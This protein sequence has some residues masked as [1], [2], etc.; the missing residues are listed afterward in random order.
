MRQFLNHRGAHPGG[1][2]DQPRESVL[3][4][5]ILKPHEQPAAQTAR[6]H[7]R[8]A[9]DLRARTMRS[10][11]T[12]QGI[13]A[14][15]TGQDRAQAPVG[16]EHKNGTGVIDRVIAAG[17]GLDGHC[18]AELFRDRLEA[19]LIGGGQADEFGIEVRHEFLELRRRVAFGID[20]HEDDLRQHRRLG[21]TQTLLHCGQGGER[22]R[23]E[24][25]AI[26]IAE[27][28]QRPVAA[29]IGGPKQ[30]AFLVDQAKIRQLAGTREI[31]SR[32][33]L[34]CGR[35]M[36][37]QNGGGDAGN[38]EMQTRAKDRYFD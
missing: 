38:T 29:K 13:H 1:R 20:G 34:D 7:A 28:Q 33:Q 19:R 10:K 25:R 22:G 18:D 27:K 12:L 11:S 24:I 8:P 6:P 21:R 17:C 31:G 5:K 9:N 35:G 3:R 16:R 32:R 26:R 2:E 4:Q 15:R 37:P 23:A 36:A 14:E 30:P